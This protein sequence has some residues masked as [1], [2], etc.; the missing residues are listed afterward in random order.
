M[1]ALCPGGPQ[2][3]E[4]AWAIAFLLPY[5]AA[6]DH[7]QHFVY[8]NPQASPEDRRSFWKQLEATYVPWRRYGGIEHLERGGYWQMQRHIYF[9]PFY[10]IDYTLAQCCA[11][12]FWARS[13]DDYAGALEDYT[14]LC[15]RGGQLPFQQLVKS[16]GL[17]SPFEAGV[18][19]SVAQRAERAIFGAQAG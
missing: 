9:A 6:V 19:Q 12:Q 16:A 10:Y 11:L 3:S 2:G 8:E 15:K 5:A 7:F 1:R 13:Q 18:L 4:T 14:A 17:R